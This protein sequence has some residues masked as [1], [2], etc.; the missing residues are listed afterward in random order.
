MLSE[1]EKGYIDWFCNEVG[2]DG[3]ER[4]RIGGGSD[5]IAQYK[6]PWVDGKVIR[7]TSIREM[8]PFIMQEA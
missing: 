5:I 2:E 1:T 8:K 3:L 4:Y 7:F 6:I